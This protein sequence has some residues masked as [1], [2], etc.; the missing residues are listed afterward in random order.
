M[1]L[2]D[3]QSLRQRS[4][5]W[6]RQASD[7][8]FLGEIALAQAELEHLLR[9]LGRYH[10]R[11]D[12]PELSFAL[13][14]AAVNWAYW[15]G[16]DEEESK[17]FRDSFMAHS[18]GYSDLRLWDRV[19]GPA[20]EEAICE[21]CKQPPRCGTYRYVGLILRH[22]GV[23]HA[24][25]PRLAQLLQ[26]IDRHEGWPNV[27]AV[28]DALL[29]G[30]VV[31]LFG[32]GCIGEHLSSDAGLAY[33]RSLCA[34]LQFLRSQPRREACDLP[35]YR[36]GLLAALLTK[37]DLGPKE[38][39]RPTSTLP[40]V[41]FDLATGRVELVFDQKAVRRKEVHC[42]QWER[43]LFDSRLDLGPGGVEPMTL[44][45]GRQDG[46][47]WSVKGWRYTEPGAWA[48]LRADGRLVT[49]NQ[50]DDPVPTGEYVLVLT[51]SLNVKSL[52]SDAS[53]DGERFLPDGA[54]CRLWHIRVADGDNGKLP[55]LQVTT[56]VVP[57]VA[58][59]NAD[60]ITRWSQ[61]DAVCS[62]APVIQIGGWTGR[63]SRRF[64]LML[65][66]SDG[67]RDL[68]PEPD[69]DGMAS[70]SLHDLPKGV[71]AEITLFPVGFQHGPRASHTIRV[72]RF[73]GRVSPEE[74]LWPATQEAILRVRVGE[75]LRLEGHDGVRVE[76]LA[77][78][79]ALIVPPNTNW[80]PV[81]AFD[82]SAGLP[83]RF[84]VR[85]CSFCFSASPGEPAIFDRALVKEMC[86]P[87]IAARTF[88]MAAVPG[89][90]ASLVVRDRGGIGR[91]W[92]RGLRLGSN[93][94][95]E[96]PATELVDVIRNEQGVL[97]IAIDCNGFEVATGSVF[98][99][100]T[101]ADLV[102]AKPWP[103]AVERYLRLIRQPAADAED[104][105]PI[106]DVEC[107]RQH[108]AIIVAVDRALGL[109]DVTP[110]PR[111]ISSAAALWITRLD[112]L[113]VDLPGLPASGAASWNAALLDWLNASPLP[114][115]PVRW[116][117]AARALIE[118]VER[119]VDIS[120]PLS[121]MLAGE[122]DPA[123]PDGLVHGWS[124]YIEAEKQLSDAERTLLKAVPFFAHAARGTPPWSQVAERLKALS[125]L[126]AGAIPA[127]IDTVASFSP[128]DD[129][130]GFDEDYRAIVCILAMRR[131]QGF[132]GNGNGLALSC[133]EDDRL[134][135]AA[136]VAGDEGWLRAAGHCW[137][138]AWLGWR[139]SA[140]IGS[141]AAQR[142]ECRRIA[143][144][145]ESKVPT[146]A[147]DTVIEELRSGSARPVSIEMECT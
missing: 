65:S 26:D 18:L 27:P 100:P 46:R 121:R 43:R 114:L 45:T 58:C 143:L 132:A 81:T 75:G 91:A 145:H 126:R 125:L 115:S 22:A 111:L 56:N 80:A 95:L 69:A 87:G 44:Y 50:H 98:V 122:T 3:Y 83:L 32:S 29:Q 139:V 131:P 142:E 123:L 66:T 90:V 129:C 5:G 6:R 24:K 138:A 37:I 10:Q 42:D 62:E 14:V 15:R 8:D 38:A 137:L 2:L 17:G 19:W 23:P 117:A 35:G 88:S 78:D 127:F 13:A 21:W 48:L 16:V 31:A 64:R 73:A 54:E 116:E 57:G 74:G 61:Y 99:Q 103:L 135:G 101:A 140:I 119:K 53:D 71:S 106:A 47:T 40:Y 105:E 41:I 68:H 110:T 104:F 108:A 146:R 107:L 102:D 97:E 12:E 11:V 60:S 86:A 4:D 118:E 67:H 28:R 109:S 82:G 124:Y 59:V 93:G 34:D 133:R 72:I 136:L 36:P 128:S 1:D 55:G 141:P 77:Q 112:A 76:G 134:L 113:L 144:L 33:L 120:G 96:I 52:W 147:C 89:A 92:R 51:A 94:R 70:I 30:H 20:I 9:S 79:L 85:R 39:V 25:I 84:P 49:T 7:L 63:N 130:R